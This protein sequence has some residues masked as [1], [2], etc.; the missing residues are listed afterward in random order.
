MGWLAVLGLVIGACGGEPESAATR[1]P[2]P[3][4]PARIV[5]A[6]PPPRHAGSPQVRQESTSG[7]TASQPGTAEPAP[8]LTREQLFDIGEL[9]P[10]GGE[11]DL[12][13][14]AREGSVA[15]LDPGGGSEISNRARYR[16][17]SDELGPEGPGR[18]QV[19][20]AEGGVAVPV[21]PDESVQLRGGVRV[22]YERD[23]EGTVDGA[24]PIPTVGVELEF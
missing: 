19:G 21:A 4:A 17:Q 18:R 1:A 6:D 16:H 11:L 13:A 22:D 24:E 9:P 12:E 20:T 3:G 8:R 10:A 23:R 5:P 15:P 7:I 2:E 14:I